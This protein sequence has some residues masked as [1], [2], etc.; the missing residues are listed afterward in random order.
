M[1]SHSSIRSQIQFLHTLIL[2][3]YSKATSITGH[4]FLAHR[5]LLYTGFTLTQ[6]PYAHAWRLYIQLQAPADNYNLFT[7]Y[8]D[9]HVETS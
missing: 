2:D 4:N 7:E 6:T 8:C 5:W 3:P 1:S 9:I